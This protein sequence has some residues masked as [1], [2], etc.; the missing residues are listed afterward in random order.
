M[1]IKKNTPLILL[2]LL[3]QLTYSQYTDVVNSNRPGQSM[4]AFSIGKNV[5]QVEGGMYGIKE[6]HNLLRYTADGFGAD[7]DIRYGFFLEELEFIATVKYQ[8][9][10]YASPLVLAN[11][12]DF[13][14][15]I[16]GAK[17]LVYDPFKGYEK[18]QNLY[19]WK[20][21]QKFEWR[22]LIPAVSVYAGVNL[23][24]TDSP[25]YYSNEETIGP[26]G[27]LIFQH[28]FASKWV[29]VTNIIYDKFTSEYKS[30]GYIATLTRGIN[31]KWS[32]FA[33]NQGIKGDFYSDAIV[34]GGAA[35][36]I[37]SDLQIDASI[38]T[39]FKDTP[40]ILYGGAGFS[41][42]FDKNH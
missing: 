40:S 7:L 4:M 41:W 21:N 11:R 27:M 33:E 22:Q 13:K 36:L 16:V 20:A 8:I 5:I 39:N 10:Q 35:Y 9:D 26:K 25:Y 31:S 17:H 23:N 29:L 12:S 6:K 34:R 28:N 19:S 14:N 37:T 15:L 42:R 1:I 3:T 38:S 24:L 32:A 18:K 30:L 2:S